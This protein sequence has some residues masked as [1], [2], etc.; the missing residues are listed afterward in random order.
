MCTNVSGLIRV[1]FQSRHSN[2]KSY[3]TYIHYSSTTINNSCCDC[4]IGDR[5]VGICS[6]RAAAIWFLSYQ[7]HSI[8]PSNNQPSASYINHLDDSIPVEDYTESSDEDSDA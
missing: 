2:S 3:Y 6:H 8:E 1:R 5:Q 4:P 7:R